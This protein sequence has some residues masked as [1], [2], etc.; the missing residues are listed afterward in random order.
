MNPRPFESISRSVRIVRS[1][2]RRPVSNLW[3]SL[4][5]TLDDVRFPSSPSTH[6]NA[7][8]GGPSDA[9]LVGF[10]PARSIGS[11]AVAG[12]VSSAARLERVGDGVALSSHR[13]GDAAAHRRGRSLPHRARGDRSRGKRRRAREH[14]RILRAADGPAI[15]HGRRHRGG[16]DDGRA[17]RR[18]IIIR[19]APRRQEPRRR[20]VPAKALMHADRDDE[21]PRASCSAR[22]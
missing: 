21:G 15:T 6:S 2:D 20:L 11:I 19:H 17:V 10:V 12:E 7:R 5:D 9:W 22:R 1:I 4:L 8:F 13:A 18:L 16:V 14:P 3:K